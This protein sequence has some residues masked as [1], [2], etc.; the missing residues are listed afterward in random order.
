M[1]QINLQINFN[2]KLI[3]AM[4]VAIG[5]ATLAYKIPETKAQA[6]PALTG[7]FGCMLNTNPLAY[8]AERTGTYAFINQIGVVDF[9]TLTSNFSITNVLNFNTV[10]AT[11]QN[12]EVTAS[13]SIVPGPFAGAFTITARSEGN[14]ADYILIPVNSGNTLLIKSRIEGKEIPDTGVCQRI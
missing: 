8:L 5:I 1:S 10:R 12:D 3:A 4:L 9:D 14:T 2:P 6:S 13:Y 7:K 11:N